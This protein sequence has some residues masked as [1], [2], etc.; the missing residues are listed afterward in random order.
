MAVS[1]YAQGH[2]LVGRGPDAQGPR[3]RP[4]GPQRHHR[5]G[6]RRHRPDAR[7]PAGDPARARTRRRCAPPASSA[8]R[9]AG[10]STSRS[11]TSASRSRT[12]SSSATAST[13]PSSTATCRTSA[14]STSER[15]DVRPAP[16]PTFVP[17]G[18]RAR[19]G[20]HR[21]ARRACSTCR[22]RIS[23][24]PVDDRR[25]HVV[26]ARHVDEVRDRVVHR[27]LPRRRSSPRR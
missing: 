11:S 15:A 7:L 5:R 24:L 19:L 2:D 10:R 12:G 13:T 27:R 3:L 8:S 23:T 6:H 1:S 25:P 9:R 18:Q 14:C 16:L 26:A 17:C 4:R 22:S 20:E 21:R